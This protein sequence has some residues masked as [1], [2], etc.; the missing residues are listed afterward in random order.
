MARLVDALAS[1]VPTIV[2]NR[3][4]LADSSSLDSNVDHVYAAVM[5]A[6]IAGSTALAE[7][8]AEQGA[9]G[10]EQLSHLFNAYFDRLI[11]IVAS[12]G[13]DIASFAGDALLALWPVPRADDL[14]VA[15]CR[16]AQCALSV[17]STL[18]GFTPDGEIHL[19]LHIGVGAGEVVVADLS[20]GGDRRVLVTAGAGVVQSARGQALA[21]GGDV[22]LSPEAWALVQDRCA[23]EM[24]PAGHVHL[25]AVRSPVSLSALSTPVAVESAEPLLRAYVPEPIRSPLGAGHGAWLDELRR[26]TVL[27]V[28]LPDLSVAGPLAEVQRAVSTLRTVLDRF[29]GSLL[30]VTVADKGP[31][32]LVAFGLPPYALADSA[33]RGLRAALAV[34]AALEA[35]AQRCSIGV[36]TGRVFSGNIGNARRR[37][38][39][40]VGDVVN[41]AARLTEVAAGQILVDATTY[42][43]ARQHFTFEPASEILARGRVEPVAA[44]RL[45][46]TVPRA[47]P[48]QSPMIGRQGERAVLQER[49][50]KLREG[51]GG[52][53][54]VIE[55]EPGIGKTRLIEDLVEQAV[56]AGIF[57]LVGAA[58]AI[59]H[60][61]PYHAWRAIFQRLFDLD[62]V[63]ATPEEWRAKILSD[64]S[65]SPSGADEGTGRYRTPDPLPPLQHLAPL[66]SAVLPLDWPENDYTASL[67]HEARTDNTRELLIRILEQATGRSPLLLIIEDVHWLD[68][69]SWA[70]LRLASVRMRP[71][72]IV[73]TGRPM[74]DLQPVEYRQILRDSR[75]VHLTLEA[76][77]PEEILAVVCQRLGV[78]SLPSSVAAL[79]Q[80]RAE[81]HPFY[82]VEIAYALR[83]SGQIVIEGSTCQLAPGVAAL[84]TFDLPDTIEGIVTSRIDR[85]SPSEQLSLKVASVIGRIFSLQ[86]LQDAHP[87]ASEVERL[88]EHLTTMERLDLVLPD[89]RE[90]PQTYLFKHAIT[91]E[92]AYNLMLFAQRR[93][94]HRRVATHYERVYAEELPR[95]YP[96]LAHHWSRALASPRAEP[97][98]AQKTIEFL[99]RAGEQASRTFADVEVVRFLSEAIHLDEELRVGQDSIDDS[100]SVRHARWERQLGEAYFRMGRVVEARA[101]LRRALEH[102]GQ[103]AATT[104][105]AL[106]TDLLRQATRQIL[107]RVF[108]IAFVGR[109]PPDAREK[110]LEAARTYD[111]L[112]LMSFIAAERLA[113]VV[114]Y[115]RSHNLAEAAGPSPELVN[116][117]AAMGI[118]A[119]AAGLTDLADGYFRRALETAQAI[120]DR[121]S[122]ARAWFSQG[123]HLVGRAAW[124]N[125]RAAFDRAIEIFEQLGDLRWVELTRLNR[126]NL[127]AYQGQFASCRQAYRDVQILAQRRGDTQAEAWA[128]VGQSN[129]C[130]MLGETDEALQILDELDRFLA[131]GFAPLSDP[132]SEID[133]RGI[134]ALALVRRRE[135][136][137]AREAV[138]ATL[139]LMDRSATPIYHARTGYE[140]AASAALALWE[141]SKA[142]S[143]EERQALAALARRALRHL[144]RF[145]RLFRMARPML[146]LRQGN[147]AWLRGHRAAA[148]RAWHRCLVEAERLTMPYERALAHYEIGRHAPPDD[149]IRQR[150]LQ[151]AIAGFGSL[152]AAYDLQ[153]ARDAASTSSGTAAPDST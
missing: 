112:A 99:E 43:A 37:A 68:S 144:E 138:E 8:L 131:H 26:V 82:A 134:R 132:G 148:T 47:R 29:E 145:A 44:Y 33:V 71:S 105:Q 28:Q 57:T 95:Y 116:S 78:G 91:Q 119:G 76:M 147:D 124:E 100:A 7:R 101:H 96:V 27:F 86:T 38:H 66:L 49:L 113:S 3:I 123:Y 56:E 64:L 79:I 102:L 150:S 25:S 140:H 92:V 70:L 80:A 133:A 46:E 21:R 117:G 135:F 55:G 87:I 30:S 126:T 75:T 53:V 109:A 106:L 39:T 84:S 149:P 83:D 122:L 121:H 74:P 48:G 67:S 2:L 94:I 41:L 14:A 120:E 65:T 127:T 18:N 62:A 107:H 9:A 153:S 61:T 139:A 81:G 17:L 34:R 93:Q 104:S 130:L 143:G 111:L 98:V 59:E 115:L 40:I 77:L 152:G 51:Q 114:G 103:P 24:L 58:D 151:E 15:T 89:Q 5:L 125:G 141:A 13:G 36:A 52:G 69:A 137:A 97:D 88:S 10:V 108:P 129:M 118:L 23:G 42:H 12:H 63:S 50:Q 4:A 1:Y 32:A 146:L 45:L 6:D 110:L 85:L 72:M 90:G 19:A 31:T 142:G 20:G 35:H 54:V 136:R 11:E 22:V 73:L 60:S 16:A 128:L